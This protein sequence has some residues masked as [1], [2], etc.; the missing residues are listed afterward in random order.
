M[1]LEINNIRS[2]EKILSKLALKN[3]E[4]ISRPEILEM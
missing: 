2:W 3:I 1:G 4:I